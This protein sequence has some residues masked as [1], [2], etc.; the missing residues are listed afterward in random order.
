MS[1]L[2][3]KRVPGVQNYKPDI[4]DKFFLTRIGIDR[5]LQD[6]DANNISSLKR[7]LQASDD[8]QYK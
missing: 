8:S 6:L 3:K 2:L 4:F 7:L 1:L 5:F